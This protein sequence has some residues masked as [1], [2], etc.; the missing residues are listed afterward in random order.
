[1]TAPV[2]ELGHA[3]AGAVIELWHATGLT[4]PWNPPSAD[5]ARAVDGPSSAVL[6]IRDAGAIIATAMVGHD[7]H[8]GWVYYLAVDPARRRR[9]LGAQLMRAAESWVV[10]MGGVKLQLMVRADNA[11]AAGFYRS[12]GYEQQPVTVLGRRLADG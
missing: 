7:G 2:E 10:A 4:R 12:L 6:G 8:R 11:A 1:M 9:G 3:D 5:F